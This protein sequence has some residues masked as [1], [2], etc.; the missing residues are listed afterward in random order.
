MSRTTDM[1]TVRCD[2]ENCTRDA[3]LPVALRSQ[4]AHRADG[5]PEATTAGWLFVNAGSLEER[6]YCP[7]CTPHYMKRFLPG[8][9]PETDANLK[10]LLEDHS[11]GG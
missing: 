1:T 8:L 2:G 5:V 11:Y 4:I 10:N 6:H 7:L 9:F 3:R